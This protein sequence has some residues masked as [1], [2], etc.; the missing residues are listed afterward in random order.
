MGEGMKER[1]ATSE[2]KVMEVLWQE[3]DLLAST[4]VDRLSDTKWSGKTIKTLIARLVKK[5]LIDYVKEGKSYRYSP[6]I[7]KSECVKQERKDFVEK[8]FGGSNKAFL[9]NFIKDEKLSSDD[10]EEL[11]KILDNKEEN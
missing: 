7:N 9:A 11:R 10:I 6:L 4:I 3:S 5:G 1:V 2:W 8:I